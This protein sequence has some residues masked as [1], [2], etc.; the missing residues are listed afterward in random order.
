MTYI[1]RNGGYTTKRTLNRAAPAETV[2]RIEIDN[3]M[4]HHYDEPPFRKTLQN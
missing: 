2:L 4:P 1:A 3:Y